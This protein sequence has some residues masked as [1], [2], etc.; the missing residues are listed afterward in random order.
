MRETKPS[1]IPYVNRISPFVCLFVFCCPDLS[2]PGIGPVPPAVEAQS[3]N[4]WTA[5]EVPQYPL[6]LTER[7][8]S[9]IELIS[10]FFHDINF[11]IFFSSIF[12]CF[13]RRPQ[14]EVLHV[15]TQVYRYTYRCIYKLNLQ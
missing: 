1:N 11:C 15:C 7:L 4:H 10:Y 8:R 12:H 3:L 13:W 9:T 2:Q 6:L 14:I 5:R